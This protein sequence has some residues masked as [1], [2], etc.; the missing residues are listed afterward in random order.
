MGKQYIYDDDNIDFK[1]DRNIVW[2]HIVK[3]LKYLVASISLAIAYYI[4][5]AIF[6]NT[7]SE[8]RLKR[9]NRMYEKLYPEMQNKEKLLSD[10]LSALQTRDDGVYEQLFQTDAP[11]ID[12]LASAGV[13]YDEDSI[14]DRDIVR[15]VEQKLVSVQKSAGSVE[16]NFRKIIAGLSKEDFSMPPMSLPVEEFTYAQT[17]A[18]IGDKINPFYKV[19]VKHRGIDLILP[20]GARVVASAPGVVKEVIRSRQGLGNVVVIDHGNGYVTR[21]AHLSDIKVSRGRIVEKGTLLG[22]VG[23]SGSTFAPHLHYEV[24]K[25]TTVMNPV[26]Y[27]FASLTPEE[28]ANMAIISVRTLQSLD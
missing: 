10:A 27:F 2:R 6:I 7:D 19:P 11:N 28:Y 18:S 5:F 21:Y 4:I 1:K 20:S 16:S 3:V 22:Y 25:D 14:P 24:L 9:E 26:N 13:F 23:V 15:Y 12:R 8:R 17:G